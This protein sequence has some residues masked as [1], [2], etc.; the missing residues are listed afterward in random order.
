M[1]WSTC[2]C[3]FPITTS[4]WA[5]IS[6]MTMWLCRA[7]ASSSM[8]W[9][10][11]SVK[12]LSVSGRFKTSLASSQIPLQDVQ[13]PSQNEWGKTLDTTGSHPGSEEEHEPGFVLFCFC[14]FWH[15][16]A[17]GS[18]CAVPHLCDVLENDFLD[19]VKFIKK[20][21]NYLTNLCRLTGE[22]FL[23]KADPQA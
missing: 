9:L 12:A 20:M 1:A 19:E 7:R 13:K 6:T 14:Y 17:L 10:R 21:G 2:T 11:R 22:I 3:R 15:L 23:Q 5:F 4:L 8:S 18:A 16:H